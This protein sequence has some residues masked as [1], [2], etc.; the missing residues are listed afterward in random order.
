MIEALCQQW[1]IPDSSDYLCGRYWPA[2]SQLDD[3]G[4]RAFRQVLGIQEENG[5][6][7]DGSDYRHD[8]V[9]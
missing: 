7:S 8:L 4:Q 1:R 3:A 9:S 6:E 5:K 2:F